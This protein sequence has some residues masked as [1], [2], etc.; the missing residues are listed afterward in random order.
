MQ[1]T[2]VDQ[3]TNIVAYP[4]TQLPYGNITVEGSAGGLSFPLD[5]H[6]DTQLTMYDATFNRPVNVSYQGEHCT[7]PLLNCVETK[8]AA[9]RLWRSGAAAARSSGGQEQQLFLCTPK[10]AALF[11]PPL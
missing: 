5:V 10:S 6:P 8:L 2:A 4:T 3:Q 9:G 11:L 7:T 1:A